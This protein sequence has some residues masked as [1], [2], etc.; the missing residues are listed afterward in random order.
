M[1]YLR[2]EADPDPVRV[3]AA[4]VSDADIRAMTAL[5]APPLT[6]LPLVELEPRIA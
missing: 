6:A 1:G 4:F 2:L 5:Y 3:R